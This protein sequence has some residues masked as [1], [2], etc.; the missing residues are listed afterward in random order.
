MEQVRVGIHKPR[1]R[2]RYGPT[3][4]ALEKGY[5]ADAGLDIVLV[6]TGGRRGAIPAL[7]GSEVDASPQSPSLDFFKALDPLRPIKMVADH[8]T[9]RPGR[10]TGAIVARRELIENGRLREY[11]DLRGLRVGLS[12]VVGDHDWLT[13]DSALV[14]GGLSFDDVR[15]VTVDFGKVRHE[16]LANGEVDVATIGNPQ[17]IAAGR[18]KGAYVPWK[19]EHEVRP[20]RQQRAVM[21]GYAFWFE[22]PEAACNYLAGYLRGVRDYIRAFDG[23]I[24]REEVIQILCKQSGESADF[25]EREMVPLALHPEGRMHIDGIREDL[26][27]FQKRNLVPRTIRLEDVVDESYLE[28][29]RGNSENIKET[30]HDQP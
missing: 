7:A 13:F 21:F 8:G 2:L 28:R 18:E 25:I 24:G 16:A 29:A 1:G 26:E 17:S 19:Y 27:W 5:F 3:L 30:R 22:K 15:L 10:G 20:G 14:R 12:P 4:I 11:E 9:V 6:E 23:G